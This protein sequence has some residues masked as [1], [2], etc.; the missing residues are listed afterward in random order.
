MRASGRSCAN[1]LHLRPY[2]LDMSPPIRTTLL[3]LDHRRRNRKLFRAE[4]A[5]V[6]PGPGG[7]FEL[8]FG[9]DP[10]SSA[11]GRP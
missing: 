6:V 5:Q 4:A 8:W 2:A 3:G 11:H 9:L 7:A 1:G 10:I